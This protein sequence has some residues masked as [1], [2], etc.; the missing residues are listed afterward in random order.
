M[1]NQALRVSEE[2]KEGKAKPRFTKYRGTLLTVVWIQ[3]LLLACALQTL[4]IY[5]I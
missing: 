4:L 2:G 5:K 1:D 3:F